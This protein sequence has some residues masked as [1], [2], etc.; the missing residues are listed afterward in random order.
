MRNGLPTISRSVYPNRR[1]APAFQLVTIPRREVAVTI[2]SCVQVVV[3]RSRWSSWSI[4]RRSVR[5]RIT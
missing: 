5:S 2:A 4:R 3:T 1:C